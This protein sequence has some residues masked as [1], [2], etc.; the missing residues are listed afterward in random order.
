M[1]LWWWVL[2]ISE[3][4]L[5]W[6][7]LRSKPLTSVQWVKLPDVWVAVALQQ[8]SDTHTKEESYFHVLGKEGVQ[9]LVG[10]SEMLRE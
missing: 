6:S 10:N 9:R 3:V 5:G 1:V 8:A 2:Q 4:M 7:P